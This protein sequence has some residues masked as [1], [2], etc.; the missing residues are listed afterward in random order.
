MHL[1][2]LWTRSHV[3]FTTGNVSSETI[4]QW[5]EHQKTRG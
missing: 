5:I 2:I 4:K 1:Q 3:V